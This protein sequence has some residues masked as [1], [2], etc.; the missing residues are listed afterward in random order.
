MVLPSGATLIRWRKDALLLIVPLLL[1]Y[2]LPTSKFLYYI[3]MLLKPN[4]RKTFH[5]K[6]T[7]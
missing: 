5:S 7:K 1:C 3:A 4:I 2:E 6:I